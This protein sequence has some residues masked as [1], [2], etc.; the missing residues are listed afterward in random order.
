MPCSEGGRGGPQGVPK[1]S[2]GDG[3]ELRLSASQSRSAGLAAHG[4]PPTPRPALPPPILTRVPP[5]RCSHAL[6]PLAS[7][8]AAPGGAVGWKGGGWEQDGKRCA[9]PAGRRAAQSSARSS[10]SP[11]PSRHRRTPEGGERQRIIMYSASS[12]AAG[13]DLSRGSAPRPPGAARRPPSLPPAG[14]CSRRSSSAT[15]RF[16]ARA[17][18]LRLSR[19]RRSRKELRSASSASRSAGGA[20]WQPQSRAKS[21][22]CRPRAQRGSVV[23]W[24]LQEG[25]EQRMGAA[26]RPLRALQEMQSSCHWEHGGQGVSGVLQQQQGQ[27][28][29][30]CQH[31]CTNASPLHPHCT[32]VVPACLH[33]CIPIA[34]P[35]CLQSLHQCIHIAPHGACNPCTNASPLH[36]IAPPWC[37]HPCTNAS[38]LHPIAPHG[39]CMPAP[40]ALP[41]CLHPCTQRSPTAPHRTA[42][43][44]PRTPAASPHCT[45]CIPAATLRSSTWTQHGSKESS[46][47]P[48]L[49]PSCPPPAPPEQQQQQPG[50]AMQI[51]HGWEALAAGSSA[52]RERKHLAEQQG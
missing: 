5:W 46:R 16:L 28:A 1:G 13:G 35:W 43:L 19:S 15:E 48:L 42:S 31:P 9:T 23:G 33:Q 49:P 47:P 52:C 2:A 22:R 30:W 11:A 24:G 6:P 36:P 37:L 27:A 20:A 3:W 21:H 4:R 45:Q 12:A 26:W 40:I 51:L 32:P 41:C 34:S 38:P 14:P 39:A 8:A 44:H 18:A 50:T 10:D 29:S 25:G 17:A 7:I